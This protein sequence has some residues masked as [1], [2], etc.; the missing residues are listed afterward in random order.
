MGGGWAGAAAK[1]ARRGIHWLLDI[2]RGREERTMDWERRGS[3]GGS[4]GLWGVGVAGAG[5]GPTE[6]GPE[7]GV[8]PPGL[9]TS[10]SGMARPS[11]GA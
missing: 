6:R 3:G 7:S 11:A 2:R 4:G 5:R 10:G 1:V 8:A 9:G